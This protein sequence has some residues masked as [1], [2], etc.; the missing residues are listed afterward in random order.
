VKIYVASSWRNPEQPA[1]VASLR[2]AGH[3]VYDF[4][5]PAPD[6]NGFSWSQVDPNWKGWSPPEMVEALQHPVSQ[7]G[8]KL[9][10]DALR[11]AEATVLVMPCGRSAHLELGFAVGDGQLTIAYLGAQ[12]AEPELMYLMCDVL[13]VSM[14]EV[15][16]ALGSVCTIAE[17]ERVK[18]GGA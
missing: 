1:V 12:P 10:M 11:W 18:G 13:A 7:A 6:N 2:A 16:R 15:H 17:L 5:H 8:F 14:D 3:E 9:D 4:R